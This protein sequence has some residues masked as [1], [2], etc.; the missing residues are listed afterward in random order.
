MRYLYLKR[1]NYLKY[2][3]ST[4]LSNTIFLILHMI[5]IE[6]SNFNYVCYVHLGNILGFLYFSVF[7]CYHRNIP[8]HA[9]LVIG[10]VNYTDILFIVLDFVFNL[11]VC[12]ICWSWLVHYCRILFECTQ[13]FLQLVQVKYTCFIG[14][15]I[16]IELSS[17]TNSNLWEFNGLE[18]SV[19]FHY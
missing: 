13:L 10:F 11:Y 15:L 1:K 5:F 8:L 2:D 7:T 14:S 17:H 9:V 18:V 19:N 6:L 16:F 4:L 12:T 3:V